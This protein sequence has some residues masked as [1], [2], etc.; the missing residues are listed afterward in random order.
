MPH[1]QC[2]QLETLHLGRRA[3]QVV[4]QPN[5]TAAA[6]LAHRFTCA[7]RDD[8]G[9]R[10]D[11]ERRKQPKH[12]SPLRRP[13]AT[14]DLGD[15]HHTDRQPAMAASFYQPIACRWTTLANA[16]SGCRN[17]PASP[18]SMPGSSKVFLALGRTAGGSV[19]VGCH[20]ERIVDSCEILAAARIRTGE[21]AINQ[22]AN[23]LGARYALLL[24]QSVQACRLLLVEID[25]GAPHH[26]TTAPIRAPS[27]SRTRAPAPF[28]RP[29]RAARKRRRPPAQS[30]LR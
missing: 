8:L 13:H 29:G 11:P 15:R 21:S 25:V 14:N 17:Q 23:E 1:V 4:A 22:S 9:C 12:L 24:G 6:I 7:S 2:R 10:L 26:T 27:P 19:E 5:P 30:C 18:R 28:R 16:R 20:A 3:N